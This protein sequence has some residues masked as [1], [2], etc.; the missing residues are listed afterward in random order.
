MQYTNFSFFHRTKAARILQQKAG[1]Q[2][3][4]ETINPFSTGNLHQL[5]L[6]DLS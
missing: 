5:G 2:H 6:T 4:P 3:T 1:L